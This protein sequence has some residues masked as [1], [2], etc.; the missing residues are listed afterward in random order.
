M[1]I[2]RPV[3]GVSALIVDGGR[4]LLVKRGNAPLKGYWSLPGGH[5]EAGETLADAAARE[6]REE[7]GI[8]AGDLRQID[9]AEI[10]GRDG[11][12]GIAHHIVLVVFAGRRTSGE[13]V[14]GDD[15]AEARWVGADEMAGLKMTEDTK[16]V[17]ALH[18]SIG[19]AGNG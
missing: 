12:S 5:V 9:L 19:Q 8:V 13:P 1:V 7:T 15:A 18:A 2:N 11:K 16:R 4:V 6:V 17:I 10:I 14:A 3:L